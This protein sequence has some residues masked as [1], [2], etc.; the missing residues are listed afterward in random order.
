VLVYAIGIGLGVP[1]DAENV[2]AN[3]GIDR[4][5]YLAPTMIGDT[6]YL[7][8]CVREKRIKREEQD[9]VVSVSWDVSN[10]NGVAVL[11]SDLNVLMA[12]KRTQGAA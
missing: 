7:K 6:L 3:Y 2:I 1:P 12:C 11:S 10:Q 5:R 9:G 8:A 4:L